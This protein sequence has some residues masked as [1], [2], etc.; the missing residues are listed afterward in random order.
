MLLIYYR[1]NLNPKF[2]TSIT[3]DYRFEEVQRLR[4]VC[5]DVDN[6]HGPLSSQDFIGE[7]VS[8]LINS[9]RVK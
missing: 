2:L 1:N 6:P 5:Y 9:K 7:M 3:V 8:K 4:F